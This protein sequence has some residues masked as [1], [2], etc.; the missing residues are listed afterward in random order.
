MF[1]GIIFV[2]GIVIMALAIKFTIATIWWNTTGPDG[3]HAAVNVDKFK[4]FSFGILMTA[5]IIALIT[6]IYGMFLACCVNKCCAILFGTFLGSTWIAILVMG[7]IVT[8]VSFA[9]QSNIQA[10]CD[11]TLTG[12]NAKFAALISDA[13]S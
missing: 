11:G 2:L 6:G 7:A 10:F 9:S 1:S 3:Y 8:S 13:I 4:N 5:G 12:T